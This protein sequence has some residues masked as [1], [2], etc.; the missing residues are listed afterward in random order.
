MPVTGML[1][2]S[3]QET[4]AVRCQIMP[5]HSSLPFRPMHERAI[6]ALADRHDATKTGT[7]YSS[8]RHPSAPVT[9]IA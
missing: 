1:Q 6:A 2:K 9:L 3:I 4:R 5:F 7:F 8:G